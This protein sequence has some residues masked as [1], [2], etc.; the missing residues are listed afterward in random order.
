M[1]NDLQKGSMRVRNTRYIWETIFACE[2][3]IE[4]L[5]QNKDEFPD[6]KYTDT[7]MLTETLI[8]LKYSAMELIGKDG[9]KDG[10]NHS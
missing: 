5:S 8:A 10:N 6:M 1:Y 3:L 7:Y 2:K 9:I 4:I